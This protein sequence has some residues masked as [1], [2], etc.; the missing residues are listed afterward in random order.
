MF[1]L[2]NFAYNVGSKAKL[3]YLK[4]IPVLGLWNAARYVNSLSSGPTTEH[5]TPS[6][7]G[8]SLLRTN[9]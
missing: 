5:S 3:S 8:Q 9:T 7:A 6:L 2:G 4:R 1:L